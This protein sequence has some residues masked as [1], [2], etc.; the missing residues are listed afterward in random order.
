M[1]AEF[2]DLKE[3]RSAGSGQAQ[4]ARWAEP[5]YL[6]P[7]FTPTCFQHSLCIFYFYL[8]CYVVRMGKVATSRDENGR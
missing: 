4:T 8:L 1:A 3:P 6:K 5:S 2:S 7:R